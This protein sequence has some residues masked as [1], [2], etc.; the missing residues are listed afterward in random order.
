MGDLDEPVR[1]HARLRPDAPA[2]VSGGRALTY[3]ELDREVSRAARRLA[4]GG[5]RAGD[6]VAAL[7]PAG[8]E[9]ATLLHAVARIGAA[10]VP[11]DPALAGRELRPRL[12]LAEPRLVVEEP[13]GGDE[14]D[15]PLAE[16]LDPAT[17]HTLLFTSGTSGE[18]KP[19]A[20]T[21][22]NHH[23]SARAS[24]ERLGVEEDDRWL[25]PL[26]LFHVGGL[27]VLLRS[28]INGT[29]AVVHERFDVQD[30]LDALAS[31]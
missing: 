3:A 14:E 31:G 2:L 17:V 23:A 18:S 1:L 9:L 20:L 7:L 16:T 30:V 24:A 10:L 12:E 8:S 4:A 11:L 19:V 6:R 13:L 22:E 15:V 5:V 26:P 27:A 25:C 21:H 28:A 29:A